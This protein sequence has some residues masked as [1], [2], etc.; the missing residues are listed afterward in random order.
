MKPPANY[1]L[2]HSVLTVLL[3]LSL[4]AIACSPAAT[5]E[6]PLK[7]ITTAPLTL[8]I[9]HVNDTHSYV[10]PHDLLLKFNGVD[11]LAG[12]GGYSLLNSAV[13]DIRSREKNVLLLHGGDILDGTI[14]SSKFAG[15]V[16]VDAMNTLSFDAFVPGNHEFSKSVQEAATLF[17]RAKFPILAANMDVANEPLLAGQV[18]PYAI[19]EYEEQKVGIIGLVTPDTAFL[20]YTGRNITFLP[21]E[22][23]ARQ[24]IAELNEFGVNKIVILSHLGYPMDVKLAKAVPGIDIIVGGHSATLM[25]GPEFEQIGLKPEAPYP[26]ELTGPDGGKV[27]IVQAWENN[28]MLGQITLMFDDKGRITGYNGQPFILASNGFKVEDAWGWSY[29]CSCRPEYGQIMQAVAKNPEFKLYWNSP[30]MDSI[31]QPYINQVS[32]DLN[33]VVAVADENLI[34]GPNKGPGPIIADAFLW[35]ALKADPGVQFAIYDTYNVRS[36]VYKGNILVNDVYM[37]LPLRQSLATM[38]V[39][40]NMIKMLLEMGLDSHISINDPPPCYEVSGLKLT[41]DMNRKSGD[42]ITG[43]QVRKPDGSYGDMDMQADYTM[44]ATD[45]LADKSINPLV[46][47]VSWLGPL[48]DNLKSWLK[49]YV[50]YKNLGIGDVDAM[51]DYLRAQKNV[52]NVTGERTTIIPAAK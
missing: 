25:G 51:T 18:K 23:A 24:Y 14:W 46:N 27:L 34:R 50:G 52:K 19:V 9:L 31:L 6:K 43:M 10:I 38:K 32:G 17:N 33:A 12:V 36:D 3:T 7:E 13:E 16:D 37:L 49:D 47:K 22:A 44:A 21:A 41:I 35:S 48:A 29:I 15:S 1:K 11:T 30:E 28:Q 4:A 40:G 39:K 5:I 8:T 26:T 42:R 2:R 20:G 45:Y